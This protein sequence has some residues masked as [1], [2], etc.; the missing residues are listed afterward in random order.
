MRLW[1][2]N[3]YMN[4]VKVG[5]DKIGNRRGLGGG[6]VLQEEQGANNTIK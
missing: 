3:E 2:H 5:G 6:R 4:V 1:C